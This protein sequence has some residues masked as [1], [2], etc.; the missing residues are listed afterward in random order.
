MGI[1][2]FL[3]VLITF[4]TSALLTPLVKKIAFHVGAVDKPDHK[5]KIHDHTMPSM[6]GLAIFFAFFNWIYAFLLQKLLKCYQ[7]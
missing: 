1:I 7:Y 3:I 5:R 6:G 2:Y 4:L